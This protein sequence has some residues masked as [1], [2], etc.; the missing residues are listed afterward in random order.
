MIAL[1]RPNRAGATAA[2][3]AFVLLCA[4]AIAADTVSPLPPSAYTTRSV[5]PP[6]APGHADVH[7]AGARARAR[8]RPAR[9]IPSAAGVASA[10]LDRGA[11][12]ADGDFGLRPQDLHNAYEL[13]TDSAAARRRSRSSTPTTT[14]APKPTSKPMTTS[15]ACPNAR[16]RT[17][18]SRRSTRTG[19]DRNLAVPADASEPDGGE[20]AVRGTANRR[21]DRETRRTRSSLLSVEQAEGW[22]V[23]ISLDIETA[24]AICQN[25]HIALVEAD[26]TAY[27]D[28]EA[29]EDAAARSAPARSRTRGAAR[30]ATKG[31]MPRRRA[32]RSTTPGS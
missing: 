8:R 23:E 1:T 18:A 29:A 3:A 4:P 7:G 30:N 20:D 28:L 17:A 9:T 21:N 15:S 26:S 5:C 14:S 27:E 19:S 13:P 10:T 6:P 24:H 2:V 12:P 31:R 11:L 16:K 22:S 25:C 32:P